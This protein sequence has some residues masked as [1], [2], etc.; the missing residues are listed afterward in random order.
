M[1]VPSHPWEYIK[2]TPQNPKLFLEGGFL[3]AQA[4]P[5]R[6]VFKEPV[7]ISMPAGIVV[8]GCIRLQWRFFEDSFN[9]FA[10]FMMGDLQVHLPTL[11]WL[12][13]SFWPKAAW[14]PCP[15]LSIHSILP[16]WLFLLVSLDE[17]KS[18]NGNCLLVWKRWDKKQLKH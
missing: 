8:R 5:T 16:Q 14:P 12:F 4:F 15:T 1:F 6:W 17:E 9:M 18:S 2:G 3:V 7:C 11:C 13:S 10:H